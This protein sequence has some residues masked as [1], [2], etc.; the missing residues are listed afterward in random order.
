MELSDYIRLT[1]DEIVEGVKKADKT[2]KKRE[3]AY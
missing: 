2:L 1:L 3:D